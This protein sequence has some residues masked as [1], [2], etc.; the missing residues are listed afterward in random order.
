M[1]LAIAGIYDYD[2]KD[3]YVLGHSLGVAD[4]GYFNFL[5]CAT[6]TVKSNQDDDTC[7]ESLAHDDFYEE[8][9][10]DLNDRIQY[11][12]KRYGNDKT[13][14]EEISPE[15]EK[16]FLRR[17]SAEQQER[18]QMLTDDF[19]EAL[20]ESDMFVAQTQDEKGCEEIATEKSPRRE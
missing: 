1:A 17:L 19:K 4:I 14:T 3:I 2:I 16:A 20:R 6:Q 11:V 15:E 9:L 8:S 5:S 12:I 18:N 7:N 10:S 13:I